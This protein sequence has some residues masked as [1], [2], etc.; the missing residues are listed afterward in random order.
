MEIC[1]RAAN[2]K[3]AHR[4]LVQ[5]VTGRNSGPPGVKRH[6]RVACLL[7]SPSVTSRGLA[8]KSA[9]MTRAATK[10]IR[11][12]QTTRTT[13]PVGRISASGTRCDMPNLACRTTAE[14]S[15]SVL[16]RRPGTR[17]TQRHD[18]IGDLTPEVGLLML[19]SLVTRLLTHVEACSRDADNAVDRGNGAR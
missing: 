11:A 19:F 2:L 1:P 15:P 10:P 4:G 3:V 12:R 14:L 6:L 18:G 8:L 13:T 17:R 5:F 7:A 16:K 9:N